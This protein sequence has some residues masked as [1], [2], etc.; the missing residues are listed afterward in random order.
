MIDICIILTLFHQ[1]SDCCF[2]LAPDKV[3]LVFTGPASQKL[4][5]KRNH[6]PRAVN[7]HFMAPPI[8]TVA[9]S[10][11]HPYYNFFL[12]PTSSIYPFSHGYHRWWRSNGE[13]FEFYDTPAPTVKG[14]SLVCKLL[15]TLPVDQ[16]SSSSMWHKALTLPLCASRCI[17]HWESIQELFHKWYFTPASL[18]T[19][20]TS[21]SPQCWRNCTERG[22]L[23]HIWWECPNIRRYWQEVSTLIST[24]CKV[25]TPLTPL[26]LLR[27]LSVPNWPNRVRVLATHILIAARLALAKK[28]KSPQPPTRSDLIVLLNN[29]FQ[30]EFSFAK[31][32]LT[33]VSFFQNWEPWIADPRSTAL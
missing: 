22:T 33:T 18:A 9:T 21:T 32:N 11:G 24:V 12:I 19:I 16:T 25:P 30:L 28:W 6:Q 15:T 8:L 2:G 4:D 27:G 13:H 31:A 1:C 26:D 14:I 5:T 23:Q 10:F 3:G 29:H 20:Y 7:V 17:S